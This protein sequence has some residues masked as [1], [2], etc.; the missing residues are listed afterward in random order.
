MGAWIET[1]WINPLPSLLSRIL[2]GCVDWNFN[3]F[4]FFLDCFVASYMGAWIETSKLGISRT[5][6]VKSHPTW[7]RGLKLIKQIWMRTLMLSHPTW[8]RGLKHRL[9]FRSYQRQCVASYMGAWIETLLQK[10]RYPSWHVASYMGA[11]IETCFFESN[12][13]SCSGRILHGCVDWNSAI[14]D[15]YRYRKQVASYMGAW[16]ETKFH[17]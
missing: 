8:V 16:I 6:T 2:H 11:W 10:V 4:I 7:V 13:K 5:A 1:I 17:I 3:F 14:S 15:N 12:A 9:W